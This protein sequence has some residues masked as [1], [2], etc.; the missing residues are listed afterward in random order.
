[1]RKKQSQSAFSAPRELS[2]L[3][4]RSG[5]SIAELANRA[6]YGRPSSIQRYLDEA[7]FRGSY[8]KLETAR[9]F[10]TAL[11][12]LGDPPITEAEVIALADPKVRALFKGRPI[13]V[14]SY[15]QA[16]GWTTTA[17]PYPRGQGFAEMAVDS[18]IG[19]R[20]FGLQIQG[21][22]MIDRFREGDRVA[23]DPDVQPRPGDFVVAVEERQGDGDRE[24]TFKQYRPRGADSR[25]RPIIE[26]RPLNDAWPLITLD[27]RNPGKIIGTMIEHHSYRR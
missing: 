12:G 5:L 16:G 17:D 3:R 2:A 1:M 14:I 24:A 22:S 18:A 27:T 25:G 8:L 15:V 11:E 26:L 20:A 7:S 4:L 23:I 6:G 13:P 10:A 21:D 9:R 19:P